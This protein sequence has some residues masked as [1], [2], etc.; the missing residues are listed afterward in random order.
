MGCIE[1]FDTFCKKVLRNH[2]RN[3]E[4][5]LRN[6]QECECY[7]EDVQHDLRWKT[8]IS[9]AACEGRRIFHIL[10]AEIAIRDLL[11]A[12]ALES[13]PESQRDIVLLKYFLDMKE[14]EIAE[15]M[16]LGRRTVSYRHA[17]I[18]RKLKDIMEEQENEEE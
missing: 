3:H 10:D 17:C 13:L 16:H 7:V 18:L 11:L 8:A 4:K 15:V 9:V 12:A 5:Q 1:Q 2:A 14:R 6:R